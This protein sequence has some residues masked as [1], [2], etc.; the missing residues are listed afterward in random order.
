MHVKLRDGYVKETSR[1]ECLGQGK[2]NMVMQ[3]VKAGRYQ[4]GPF[5]Y[6]AAHRELFKNGKLIHVTGKKLDILNVLIDK[7]PT[8]ISR[9]DLHSAVWAGETTDIHVVST[10]VSHLG[11]ILKSEL[12]TEGG[13]RLRH[14]QLLRNDNRDQLRPSWGEVCKAAKEVGTYLFDEFRANAILT[15]AGHSAIFA[16]LVLVKSLSRARMLGMPVYLALQRDWDQSVNREL[17]A[18]P[19]YETFLGEAVAVLV[20]KALIDQ[21]KAASKTWRIAVIDDAI[22]SGAV[23]TVLKSHLKLPRKSRMVFACYVGYRPVAEAMK[24]RKPEKVIRWLRTPEELEAFRLP[25]DTSLL[26]FGQWLGG[27]NTGSG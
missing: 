10:H 24:P 5:T 23:P 13:Y 4:L 27:A 26:W 21:L 8:R 6:D 19:G 7:F 17:P 18:L 12:M 14:R 11:T 16:N 9:Q 20:P 3:N 15:F 2:S 22:V 25:C 1:S